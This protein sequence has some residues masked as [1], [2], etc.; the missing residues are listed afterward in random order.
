MLATVVAALMAPEV[1]AHHLVGAYSGPFA[2]ALVLGAMAAAER[3]EGISEAGL[4]LPGATAAVA[5]LAPALLDLSD[6]DGA[7]PR[8]TGRT[9]LGGRSVLTA[10]HVAVD[11]GQRTVL[12]EVSMHVEPGEIVSVMGESGAGKST[13]LLV[14]AGL[15]RPT[16]GDASLGPRRLAAMDDEERSARILLV[17]SAPHLFG[18]TLAANLRL[19]APEA[20]DDDL[21]RALDAVGLGRW[22]AS[23][24]AGL[25]TKLGEGGA[26]ASGGQRQRIGL[27]RA[28]LS[29]APL[30]LLDEPASHLPEADAISALRAVMRA[31]VGRTAVLV[32]HRAAERRL[33]TREVLLAHGE[34]ERATGHAAGATLGVR[35]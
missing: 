31:R 8:R 12:R 2:A 22:V 7:A 15:L 24:P 10:D 32:S 28:I 18:G 3:L 14:L 23:L 20:T 19:A 25:E 1:A 6:A 26:T 17:P 9:W 13:L 30:V 4:A 35:S 11:R 16:S 29:P 5:R 27:A 33:A 34:I 21:L